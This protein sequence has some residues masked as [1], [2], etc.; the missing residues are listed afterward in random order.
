MKILQ[1]WRATVY[2]LPG[3]TIDIRDAIVHIFDHQDE[4]VRWA[5]GTV[6]SA[7]AESPEPHVAVTYYP[8][9]RMS[10]S[11]VELVHVLVRE[12]KPK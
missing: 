1:K 5:T 4:A 8:A 12:E 10:H 6:V 2:L 7:Y 11:T 9:H 3:H